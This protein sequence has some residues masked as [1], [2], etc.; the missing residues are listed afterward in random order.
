MQILDQF[1]H[2][3]ELVKFRHVACPVQAGMALPKGGTHP[4]QTPLRPPLAP[5]V[6]GHVSR[7]MSIS[8]ATGQAGCP[9][10]APHV[11][12]PARPASAPD[13]RPGREGAP[14]AGV[15]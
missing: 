11:P 8:A 14:D 5:I 2:E 15:R 9:M 6:K 7:K 12:A 1:H 13:Q 4:N 3:Q 10:L